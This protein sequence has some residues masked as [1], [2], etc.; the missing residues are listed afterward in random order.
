MTGNTGQFQFD[1]RREIS[2]DGLDFRQGERTIDVSM[3][4]RTT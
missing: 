3:A 4:S 2:C 1:V